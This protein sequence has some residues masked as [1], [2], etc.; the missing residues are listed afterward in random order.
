MVLQSSVL[1]SGGR[2]KNWRLLAAVPGQLA[3]SSAFQ[4]AWIADESGGKRRSVPEA[5]C[6]NRADGL[7]ERREAV[8]WMAQNAC[9][10][11]PEPRGSIEMVGAAVSRHHGTAGPRRRQRNVGSADFVCDRAHRN[12]ARN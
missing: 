2:A 10:V 8:C 1:H 3:D 4:R 11:L 12:A 5:D 9:A 7:R 6:R